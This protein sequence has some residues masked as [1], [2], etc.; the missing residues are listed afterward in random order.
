[1]GKE[2]AIE[3]HSIIIGWT[4]ANALTKGQ[5]SRFAVNIDPSRSTDARAAVFF[6]GDMV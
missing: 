3:R 1:M 5:V 6:V 2:P 4:R